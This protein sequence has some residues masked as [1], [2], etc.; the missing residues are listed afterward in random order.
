[1]LTATA[2]PLGQNESRRGGSG[3]AT[4]PVPARRVFL[5]RARRDQEPDL[6]G[7]LVWQGRRPGTVTTAAKAAPP[8]RDRKPQAL[9]KIRQEK[10]RKTR[11]TPRAI[12]LVGSTHE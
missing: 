4:G 9:T 5:Q 7:A 6:G 1:M 12:A 8:T 11:P 10:R 3:P 2:V